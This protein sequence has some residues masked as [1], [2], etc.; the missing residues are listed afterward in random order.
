MF[1]YNHPYYNH[2]VLF[3]FLL[4]FASGTS[5]RAKDR[6][7]FVPGKQA[8]ESARAK[9][10]DVHEQETCAAYDQKQAHVPDDDLR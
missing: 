4:V 8:T 1:Q 10:S 7:G 5:S 6:K 9:S 2:T 3:C